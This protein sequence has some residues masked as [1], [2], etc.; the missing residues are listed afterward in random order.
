MYTSEIVLPS[1]TCE[2]ALFLLLLSQ[3]IFLLAFCF[4]GIPFIIQFKFHYNFTLYVHYIAV[5]SVRG[6]TGRRRL[7]MSSFV[8][9]FSG[10]QPATERAHVSST[11]SSAWSFFLDYFFFITL[12]GL[13]SRSFS[14][15]LS[16]D[17]GTNTFYMYSPD[18]W[19]LMFV[20]VYKIYM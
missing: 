15:A 20:L 17:A 3:F 12:N 6:D 13:L 16:Y 5:C 1:S 7:G 8:R 2:R 9:P 14:F 19:Y 18:P 10:S 4:I 11:S